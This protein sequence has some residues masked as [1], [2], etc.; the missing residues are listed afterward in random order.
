M[1]S[2]QLLESEARTVT[3]GATAVRPEVTHKRLP[4]AGA[5]GDPAIALRPI[6]QLWRGV[7]NGLA[8]SDTTVSRVAALCLVSVATAL[9]PLSLIWDFSWE[10]SIGV[11]RFWSPPHLVTHIGVWLC[12]LIGAFLVFDSTFARSP[13]GQGTSIKI[14]ALRAPLGAWMLLWGAASLQPTFLFDNWWQQ[15]Y[16]L[17]AGLWAPPQ[18]LKAFGLFVVLA[19]GGVLWVETDLKRWACLKPLGIAW[20]ATLVLTMSGLVLT[21]SSLPNLQHTGSFYLI[22]CAVYPAILLSAKVKSGESPGSPAAFRSLEALSS[23]I[24]ALFY[25]L[26]VWSVVWVLP[27]FPAHPLTPPIRNPTTHMMPPASPLFLLLPALVLDFVTARFAGKND[28]HYNLLVSLA[29]GGGFFT[30]FVTGQWFFSSFL[31]SPWADNWFFAG[32]GQHWPFFLKIDQARTL[33]WGVKEDPFTLVKALLSALL[34]SA[35]VWLG[36]RIAGWLRNF[37]R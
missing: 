14:G 31:L 28:T 30:A 33:F 1:L 13:R 9:I 22:S 26:L 24:T 34:A 2:L 29:A 27:L 4:S 5:N 15:S 35:S 18:I 36:L 21:M 7:E 20:Q 6:N 17:G 25:M 32:G 23:T 8:A 11:D 10:S 3:N 37:R 12:G 19:G 16:G